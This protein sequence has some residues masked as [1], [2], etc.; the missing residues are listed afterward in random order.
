M[1]GTAALKGW[2]TIKGLRQ[3]VRDG[4]AGGQLASGL[5]SFCGMGLA[6]Y[7]LLYL[8]YICKIDVTILSFH[9]FQYKLFSFS[10]SFYPLESYC[11]W[12]ITGTL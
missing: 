12:S 1:L 6:Y 8:Y 9:S 10:I 11:G 2:R 7:S 5:A 3:I 4:T